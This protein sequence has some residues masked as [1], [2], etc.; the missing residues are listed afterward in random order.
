MSLLC[1]PC[2]TQASPPVRYQDCEIET[3]KF[4]FSKFVIIPCDFEFDDVTDPLE[5]E[6]GITAEDI[7]VSP[8]G[9]LVIA[10]PDVTSFAATGCGLQ[11]VGEIAYNLTFT[12]YATKKD[13]S[14]HA[15][16]KEFFKNSQQFRIIPIDCNGIFYLSSPFVDFINDQSSSN[17]TAIVG[18]SAAH[19]FSV[20]SP[21]TWI[22]GEGGKGQWSVTMQVISSD[23]LTGVYL[24]G[25]V[26]V[27]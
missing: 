24:P 3:R 25:V 14:D 20:T 12:T 13:L 19:E 10:E 6:A 8:D 27:L 5:W 26:N 2:D 11:L 17:A 16:W 23:I 15:Y 21:P 4:G 9:I 1:V 22:E 7:G 18:N